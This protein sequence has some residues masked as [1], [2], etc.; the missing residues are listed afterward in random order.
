MSASKRTTLSKSERRM[1]ISPLEY[2]WHSPMCN[3]ASN[4]A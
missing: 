1:I 3:D 2:G 4:G